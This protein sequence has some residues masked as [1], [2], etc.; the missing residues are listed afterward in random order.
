MLVR[1]HA[2]CVRGVQW[3][4]ALALLALLALMALLTLLALMALGHC[5]RC[6]Y[7]WCSALPRAVPLLSALYV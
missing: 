1:L 7:C 2:V 4:A 6:W 3:G 5:W